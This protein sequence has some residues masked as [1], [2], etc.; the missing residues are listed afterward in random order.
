M[1]SWVPLVMPLLRRPQHSLLSGLGVAGA[2]LAAVVVTFTLASGI[3]AYNLTSAD[4]IVTS[5]H[6][7]VLDPLRAADGVAAPLVLRGAG[8]AGARTGSSGAVAGGS[9]RDANATAG[10]QVKGSLSSTGAEGAGVR[11]GDSADAAGAQP[12]PGAARRPVV[13]K[14]LDDTSQAV[15]VTADSLARRL[16]VVTGTLG[17]HAEQ[18]GV[19]AGTALREVVGT[20][21]GALAHL[22]GPRLAG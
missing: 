4:P 9:P 2:V 12:T 17:S 19:N 6:A 1:T 18:L 16:E 21:T 7:I 8:D 22:L 20:G 11:A 5:S 14:A 13:G 15:G 10:G 3:V